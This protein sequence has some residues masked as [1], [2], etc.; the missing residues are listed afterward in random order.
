MK[1]YWWNIIIHFYT[2]LQCPLIFFDHSCTKACNLQNCRGKWSNLIKQHAGWKF[3]I[4]RADQFHKLE[5]FGRI[6]DWNFMNKQHSHWVLNYSN[7]VFLVIIWH[8]CSISLSTNVDT[9][10]GYKKTWVQGHDLKVQS[11]TMHGT[12]M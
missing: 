12:T 9:G 10:H 7:C 1:L 4:L 8:D 5:K 2:S 6:N 11:H 3:K